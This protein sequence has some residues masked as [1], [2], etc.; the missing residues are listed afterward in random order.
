VNLMRF[1][2][3]KCKALHLAHGN[4]HC[5][6]NLGSVRMKH[7]PDKK[8]LEVLVD[9]KLDVSQQCAFAAQKASC[10]L[11]A[12]KEV[13][14]EGGDPAPLHCETSP[15]VLCPDVESSVQERDGPVAHAEEGHR[16]DPRNGTALL[17]G[18]GER[19]G[20]VQPGE[21]KASRRPESG[22]SV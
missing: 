11:A 16:N 12:S 7:S 8:N 19:A 14:V 3:T 10:I 5:Q 18:Q 6:Y 9:W 2:Y 21:E 15:G 22:L 4:P 17:Q 13:W 20:A 1:N